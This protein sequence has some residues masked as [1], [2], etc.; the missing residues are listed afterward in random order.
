MV[1]LQSLADVEAERKALSI[2]LSH[3]ERIYDFTGELLPEH[4]SRMAYRLVYEAMLDIV[5]G[6]RNLDVLELVETMRAK[7]T[8]ERAGGLFYVAQLGSAG[9]S[10]VAI[11]SAVS[12]IKRYYMRRRALLVGERLA[13][14]AGDVTQ[15]LDIDG[16]QAELSGI[17]MGESK[18]NFYTMTEAVTKFS[19][20]LDNRAS[21]DFK[22]VL[23]GIAPLDVLLKGFQPTDLII[24]AGRSSMGKTA[25]AVNIAKNAAGKENGS[26]SVA[27]FSLEMSMEQLLSRMFAI[28]T[29]VNAENI[30]NAQMGQSQWDSVTKA[31]DYF[32]HLPVYICDQGGMTAAQIATAS[33]RLKAQKGLDLV[34]IDHLQ[35]IVGDRRA[36]NRTQE[37]AEMTKA[38]K[39]LAKELEI[40]VIVLSQL[41]R[42]VESRADK[43]PILSD[44][45]ESGAIEQDADVVMM[46]YRDRY[47]NPQGDEWTEVDVKK[48]RNGKTGMV[49][50]KYNNSL[51]KFEP[52]PQDFGGAYVK[53]KNIPM[54]G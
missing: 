46:I 8:L 24:L 31:Y 14:I 47:Y 50:L 16:I 23:S 22:N 35:L 52:Y 9:Y 2:F 53:D 15:E 39:N 12:S 26:K 28:Q 25:L 38:L 10:N 32:A 5:A 34:I 3:P 29:G 7:D 30:I 37:L 11:E 40:P 6:K 27:F 45:R 21:S 51:T 41:S 54:E 20:Y 18:G 44:L 48:R 49:K 42:A 33:R 19:N 17:M 13:E 43:R 36:E 4:F 1:E